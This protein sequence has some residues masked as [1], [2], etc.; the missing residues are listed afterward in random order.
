MLLN[1]KGSRHSIHLTILEYKQERARLI[2]PNVSWSLFFSPLALPV[3][4]FPCTNLYDLRES[5]V[6]K[7]KKTVPPFFLAL[8]GRQL[9]HGSKFGMAEKEG[10]ENGEK[11]SK[12]RK[13]EKK[14]GVSGKLIKIPDAL[15]PH[16]HRKTVSEARPK[17][18][19]SIGPL[20]TRQSTSLNCK[21]IVVHYILRI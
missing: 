13:K 19:R 4:F 14:E 6:H 16:M 21:K 10:K 11:K 2:S 9:G 8:K 7:Q 18:N 17:K 3:C 12:E 1:K 15:N 5:L 20:Q